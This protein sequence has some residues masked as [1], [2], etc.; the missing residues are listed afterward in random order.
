MK[1]DRGKIAGAAS[2]VLAV[3]FFYLYLHQL[4]EKSGV[5]SGFVEVL[6]AK[7]EIE[8]GERLTTENIGVRSI[9]RKFF[10][11]AM[12]AKKDADAVVM[13]RV[14]SPVPEGEYIFWHVLQEDAYGGF[15]GKIPSGKRAV[16]IP[17]EEL[18]SPG[19]VIKAG[20]AVD[21]IGVFRKDGELYSG[22]VLQNVTVLSGPAG[23]SSRMVLALTPEEAK[24]LLL[25]SSAG[26]LFFLLRNPGDSETI[27]AEFLSYTK[28]AE[29]R[30]KKGIEEVIVIKGKQ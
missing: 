25:A 21:I 22:P 4:R 6:I 14:I 30:F 28:F 3:F 8:R 29:T 24:T 15:A 18:S 1:L 13:R 26:T 23:D 16:A 5:S 11:S 17:A 2:G 27:P 9:P 20:D 19:E 10:S 12:V 7:R